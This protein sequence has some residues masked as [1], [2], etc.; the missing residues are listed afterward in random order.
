MHFPKMMQKEESGIE[1]SLS[2][3]PPLQ[4]MNFDMLPSNNES[5]PSLPNNNDTS[6]FQQF[7]SHLKKVSSI[8]SPNDEFNP[9]SDRQSQHSLQDDVDNIELQLQ[10]PSTRFNRCRTDFTFRNK[11][12]IDSKAYS[13]YQD[14]L[15]S[16]VVSRGDLQANFLDKFKFSQIRQS[17]EASCG[18][19]GDLDE[20]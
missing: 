20:V 17:F 11:Q 18:S 13:T 7:T 8:S 14:G 19:Q 12:K 1:S 2:S 5:K 15:K 6:T 3:I 4:K 16:F 9:Y 10:V